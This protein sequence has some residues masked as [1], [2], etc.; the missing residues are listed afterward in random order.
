MDNLPDTVKNKQVA[1]LEALSESCNV[2]KACDKAELG[3]STAYDWRASDAGFAADWDRALEIGI[4]ALEDEAHRRAFEGNDRPIVHLGKVTGTFKEYSDTLTIFL[5]KAHRPEKYRERSDIHL[6]AQVAVETM[7]ED[8][9]R[10]ELAQ[11]AALGL[12]PAVIAS[13]VENDASDLV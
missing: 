4:G 12:V 11:L 10:E 7:T 1:F 9:I 6:K 8:E 13:P 5:L 3:R 2:S